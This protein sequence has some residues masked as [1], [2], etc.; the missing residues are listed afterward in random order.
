MDTLFCL[1]L[2]FVTPLPDLRVVGVVRRQYMRLRTRQWPVVPVQINCKHAQWN[3]VT[4]SYTYRIA[5]ERYGGYNDQKFM[6]DAQAQRF[7]AS[8][9]LSGRVRYNPEHPET[10]WL[11]VS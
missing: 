1:L 8:L 3:I 4:A 9:D 10:S 7:L 2:V 6:S 11:S 5:G